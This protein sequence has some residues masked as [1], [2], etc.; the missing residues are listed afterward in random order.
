M[1]LNK[2]ILKYG[3]FFLL[4]L[5]TVC[6]AIRVFLHV[7]QP[8]FLKNYSQYYIDPSNNLAAFPLDY[9]TNIEDTRRITNVIIDE[10]PELACTV[11][12]EP[13]YYYSPSNTFYYYE[14]GESIGIY[15]RYCSYVTITNLDEIAEKELTITTVTVDFE[16]GSSMNVDL[17]QIEL[18]EYVHNVNGLDMI[19]SS[20]S[21]TGVS[22]TSYEVKDELF[23]ES[24]ENPFA[25]VLLDSLQVSFIGDTWNFQ[26]P[27][28]NEVNLEEYTLERNKRFKISSILDLSKNKEL[29]YARFEVSPILIFHDA[30]GNEFSQRINNIDYT[31]YFENWWDAYQFIKLRGRE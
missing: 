8:V 17:G 31:P 20:S 14:N 26:L 11:S 27:Y 25:E 18:Y 12:R 16:D 21:N 24:M 28:L 22:S 7:K 2:K 6:C 9:I 29:K 23:L 4:L 1:A 15:R 13:N 30:E 5:T 10:Y 3:L 19:S